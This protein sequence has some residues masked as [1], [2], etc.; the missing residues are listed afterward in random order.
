MVETVL[1]RM[2]SQTATAGQICRAVAENPALSAKLL[3]TDWLPLSSRKKSPRLASACGPPLTVSASNSHPPIILKAVSCHI[4]TEVCR[5][6]MSIRH[7]LQR[8]PRIQQTGAKTC[9]EVLWQLMDAEEGGAD[10]EQQPPKK[11]P[12]GTSA[13]LLGKHSRS[14]N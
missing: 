7:A 2:P 10:M 9:K 5:F 13:P 12:L 1:H 4:V 3:P 14:P 8:H 11:R 6:V